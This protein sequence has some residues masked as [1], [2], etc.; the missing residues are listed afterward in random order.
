MKH[1]IYFD[2]FISVR[3]IRFTYNFLGWHKTKGAYSLW[4]R[5]RPVLY[6]FKCRFSA[7]FI[8]PF[9]ALPPSNSIFTF[10]IIS[11][12][13][14]VSL[15]SMRTAPLLV[16]SLNKVMRNG[17]MHPIFGNRMMRDLFMVLRE[18]CDS[19]SFSAASV[20][21][22]AAAL[23]FEASILIF[24]FFKIDQIIFLIHG[25]SSLVF[26]FNFWLSADSILNNFSLPS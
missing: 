24:L 19:V 18:T 20:L 15:A 25:H 26:F 8:L 1:K 23:V 6:S 16:R 2:T 22:V 5:T 4:C 3:K 17:M 21:F 7:I 10:E 11:T 9:Q 12:A 14:A 13:L